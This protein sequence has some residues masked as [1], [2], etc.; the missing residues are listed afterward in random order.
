MFVSGW[1]IAIVV[2][3]LWLAERDNK[4]KLKDVEAS[5]KSDLELARKMLQD[6]TN[7][8]SESWKA[9]KAAEA[10]ASEWE[11]VARANHAA[12]QGFTRSYGDALR[13]LKIA[14]PLAFA[15]HLDEDRITEATERAGMAASPGGATGTAPLLLR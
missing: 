4:Q 14:D 10:K 3:G 2:I 6:A 12:N 9:Q 15:E 7:E 8:A 11:Q 5:W 13:R 1:I